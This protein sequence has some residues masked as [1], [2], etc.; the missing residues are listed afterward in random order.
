MK[1][2]TKTIIMISNGQIVS[3]PLWVCLG[4]LSI[5]GMGNNTGVGLVGK[6]E[7]GL[8]GEVIRVVGQ[9]LSKMSL[10]SSDDL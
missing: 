2:E 9:G 10:K 3:C 6:V 7:V 8:V 5:V 1:P 4:E